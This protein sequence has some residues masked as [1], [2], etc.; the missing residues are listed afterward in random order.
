MACL[1]GGCPRRTAPETDPTLGMLLTPHLGEGVPALGVLV[2][3]GEET[4][5]AVVGQRRAGHDDPVRMTDPWH[6]GSDTKAMTATLVSILEQRGVLS[7]GEIHRLASKTRRT[8]G[9][10]DGKAGCH[11]DGTDEET[12]RQLQRQA[13]V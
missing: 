9:A 3:Q 8:M 5:M 12:A 10:D 13:G 2:R 11:S 1:L 7:P 6:L 4:R